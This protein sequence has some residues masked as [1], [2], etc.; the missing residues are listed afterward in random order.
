MSL[1]L[2]IKDP[3][4]AGRGLRKAIEAVVAEEQRT[5]C[6]D[7]ESLIRRLRKPRGNIQIAVLLASTRQELE[8]LF[9]IGYLL[10]DLRILLVL[11][12]RKPETILKGHSL[13]PRFLT[14]ADGNFDNV[15]AV[16]R[17]M[18]DAMKSERQSM[19]IYGRKGRVVL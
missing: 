17:K 3:N 13:L 9:S 12:D 19:G 18:L 16:L 1:I 11:P 6:T 5:A 15:E 14:F 4:G 2:Y 8:E 7:M 10:C